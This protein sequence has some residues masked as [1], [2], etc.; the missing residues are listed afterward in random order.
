MYQA[1][2]E[3]TDLFSPW[4]APPHAPGS[5]SAPRR[6]PSTA[7]R[8]F[9]SALRL[10]PAF[11]AGEKI[12]RSRLREALTGAFG[13]SDAEG[14]WQWKHAYEAA[15]IAVV[16]LLVRYGRALLRKAEHPDAMLPLLDAIA[17]LEPP[18]TRRSHEQVR[19][20]QFS[21]PLL[22]AW[23]ASVAAAFRADDTVLEPSAGTGMLAAL[24]ALRIDANAGGRLH[25]NE[26]AST[27]AGLLHHCFPDTAIT[28]HDAEHIRDL[29]PDLRPSVVL[30]NPPF[31]RS[32]HLDRMRHD[33]DLRHVRAAYAALGPGG[34]LVAV[35]SSG[36]VPGNAD[37]RDLFATADP[38]PDIQFTTAVDGRLYQSRGTTYETRLTVVDKP[39]DGEARPPATARREMPRPMTSADHLLGAVLD[40]VPPRRRARLRQPRPA[41]PRPAPPP[42]KRASAP[43]RTTRRRKPT[44]LEA[45]PR[46]WGATAELDY[47]TTAPAGDTRAPGDKPY[48]PW[49][50]AAIVIDGAA[51]HPTT[52]V[53]SAAMAAVRHP[54]P[55]ARPLLPARLVTDHAL[56]DAQLES[57]VLA[58]E[59]HSEHLQATCRVSDDH[60]LVRRVDDDG[61]FVEADDTVDIGDGPRYGQ[62]V[63]FRQGWMLGDGTGCGKGRQVA[64][65]ILDRWL[66]G[67]RRALWLSQSDKLIEDARRDWQAVGGAPDD[68]VQLGRYRQKDAVPHAEGILFTTYATLRSPERNG[69]R[70]RLDQIVEWLADGDAETD[71]HG[72]DGVIVFAEAH[73]MANATGGRGAR[74][75]IAPS[76]QGRAGMRLQNALPDARVLYVSATGA[77]TIQ[78]LGYAVR[79]GLWGTDRTPFDKREK[80]VTAMEAGGVAALEIVARDLKALGLYQARALSYT[81][82]EIDILEHPITPA[83][84]EIYDEYAGGFKIIHA[85]LDDALEAVGI[86]SLG[87]TRNA[88]AKS[89]ARSAF[90]GAK[91]RFF[92]HLLTSMKC[93]TLIQA[94]ENDIEEGRSAVVQLV[95]TG[96]ALTDRRLA[97]IPA[98]E[99]DDLSVDVTPREY[100]LDFLRHAFP[101]TLHEEYE[102]DTGKIRSRPVQDKDG[103]PV[104]S[105]EAV[106]IRDDLIRRLGLLPPI[107]S[108][109]DQ[110]VQHFGDEAVAEIT[111]RSR[112]IV[113]IRDER[114]ERHAL[115]PRAG[116]ANAHETHAFMNREKRIL[117]F[118]MAG[119]TGRSY[120]A[121]L[122]AENTDRRVHYLLEPGWRADQAIQGLGRTHRTHQKSAPLFRPVTTDVKGERRFISTIARRL[123]SLGAITRGQR[124]SQTAMGDDDSALFRASDNF[125]SPYA[126]TALR[127]FYM[128]LYGGSIRGWSAERLEET[129][130]L[131]IVKEDDGALRDNL[132][133]MHTFLNR[134]LALPIAEQNELFAELETRLEANIEAAIE[135]G[136][137]NEGVERIKADSLRAASRETA[138][139]HA[140]A[141][142]D[143]EI[144]EIVRRDAVTPLTS[145]QALRIHDDDLRIGRSAE[146][147]VNA[148]SKRPAVRVQAPV[149]ILDN[150][151]IE[152]RVRL[153]RP[154]GRESLPES[155]LRTSN[156]RRAEVG[157]WRQLW[158]EETA[159]TPPWRESRLWLVTGLLLPV[160]NRLD[161]ADWKVYRLTTDEG[162]NLIGRVLTT[163]QVTALRSALGLDAR[164]GP[165]LSATE[166]FDEVTLRRGSFQLAPG[167]RLH[168]KRN[169][170]VTRAEIL[171]AGYDDLAVLTRLGCLSEI[172]S[173]R[174]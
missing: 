23:T 1:T 143:T 51:A 167:W 84:R 71:R 17:A 95:S 168:G 5:D 102:D 8:I 31:S 58:A 173:Y 60:E 139:V 125:E 75:D 156:W 158:N 11:E 3:T 55:S 153:L 122:S 114:G 126:K 28:R 104:Q 70:S 159:T 162:E 22:M 39:L 166:L 161:E 12:D 41:P 78:G 43:R 120:H 62:P 107:G 108:A 133:P 138:V 42:P 124:D 25:L 170:D 94:V 131:K 59:A 106:R 146:L 164:T 10:L 152:R 160:W 49:T 91:Q 113:R 44:L 98:S 157:R 119:N 48:H 93:P 35:T 86:T 45:L 36:A 135:A 29:L 88:Q 110:I 16:L 116:S 40:R 9:R 46:D 27:R 129:T 53:Q 100:V 15:E 83:Q 47:R 61:E 147:M 66:R 14:A 165:K 144:V 63:R 140:G 105:V 77:S 99:W 73:A 34:R 38:P 2:A 20:Q 56:S 65:V 155:A 150:G 50:P 123:D 64:A 68:I 18:Q 142:T 82:V 141:A 7:V 96:E 6:G 136:R 92:S 130:G 163:A 32:P 148:K 112:R 115:R 54:E 97:E 33:A 87:E 72:F 118:S 134:L 30:M 19:L 85:N 13:A 172:S 26:I 67:C 154:L 74:G 127:Q 80:F 171:D 169:M 4:P 101:T 79:L 76:Q 111:G 121:D 149:H 137:F 174:T 128:A 69:N 145:E 52:L 117:V 132:P 151:A 90:E 57:V 81:G 37:W 103:N 21:T 24:A 109:L 89:A